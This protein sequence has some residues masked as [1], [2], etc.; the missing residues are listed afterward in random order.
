MFTLKRLRLAFW[1]TG[2][3]TT[4]N[5]QIRMRPV[6]VFLHG[7]SPNNK[8][9][10]MQFSTQ[11]RAQVL[12]SCLLVI[13]LFCG[14]VSTSHAGLVAY[15]GFSYTN[16]NLLP[17]QG[18]GTGWGGS[19]SQGSGTTPTVDGGVAKLA[20]TAGLAQ[21]QASR[22]LNT[23]LGADDTTTW[24]RFNGSYFNSFFLFSPPPLPFGGLSLMNGVNES[25]Q[26]GKFSD[27]TNWSMGTSSGS[28]STTVPVNT[29]GDVWVRILHLA[30]NDTVKM[31][32]NPSNTTSESNLDGATVDLTGLDI[33]FNRIMLHGHHG[34]MTFSDHTWSFD[35]VRIGTSFDA[36]TA[37]PEPSALALVGLV[38]V[39][40]GAVRRRIV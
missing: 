29:S 19:W 39:G 31:W 37:V 23:T 36:M 8:L 20:F 28:V 4:T 27:G 30:G 22:N 7:L 14:L 26:I 6:G 13:A 25:L 12:V 9:L 32:V 24:I 35:N 2:T 15:D 16:G 21:S 10:P 5:E 34:G 3:S 1:K 11:R 17:G 18:G 33:S 38:V 40:M